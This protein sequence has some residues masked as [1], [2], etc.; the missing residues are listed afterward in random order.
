MTKKDDNKSEDTTK[1]KK[2]LTKEIADLRE[3]IAERDKVQE[4]LRESEERLRL[5]TENVPDIIMTVDLFGTIIA[6][7]RTVTGISVED[8]NP[9]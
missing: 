7:N 8:T 5:L 9:Y 1:I 4:A 2:V 6:I 3:T